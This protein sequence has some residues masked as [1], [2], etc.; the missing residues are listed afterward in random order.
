[1]EDGI[2]ERPARLAP[3]PVRS[4]PDEQLVQDHAERVDVGRDPDGRTGDLLRRGVLQRKRPT[5]LL[6]QRRGPATELDQRRNAEIQQPHL[7][8]AGDQDVRRLQVPMHDEPAVGVGDGA[9]HLE[10][11]A[12]TPRDVEPF[13]AAIPVDGTAI[14]VLQ[15]QI[16][17]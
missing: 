17:L 7:A 16:R 9:G 2:F 3:K 5:R 1:L 13:V 4:L 8:I 6:G 11:Q 15:R 12:Q 10:E 14:H